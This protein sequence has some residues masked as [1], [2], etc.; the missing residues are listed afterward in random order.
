MYAHQQ[1]LMWL[2]L[3]PLVLALP[4]PMDVRWR[5]HLDFY[6]GDLCYTQKPCAA[7]WETWFSGYTGEDAAQAFAE[8]VVSLGVDSMLLDALPSGA[9]FTTA[10][11]AGHAAGVP[12]FKQLE[13]SGHDWFGQVAKAL[14]ARGLGV[15]AYINLINNAHEVT[16]HPSHAW[17]EYN[18]TQREIPGACLNAPDHLETYARLAQQLLIAY[19]VDAGACAEASRP[20]TPSHSLP[21]A[22]LRPD[23]VMRGA[24]SY[25]GY[26][27]SALRQPLNADRP[28]LRWLPGVLQGALR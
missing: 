9:G 11:A 16:E 12:V 2:L 24:C 6:V 8:H 13:A 1:R 28:P 4:E 15:F 7:E 10:L 19:D 17:V 22:S 14:K 5:R 21:A 26:G 23:P 3:A 25:L 27:Y 20:R 18:H